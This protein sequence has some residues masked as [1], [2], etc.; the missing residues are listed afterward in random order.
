MLKQ[1]GRRDSEYGEYQELFSMNQAGMVN[2][3]LNAVS[4]VKPSKLCKE[5]RQHCR[6]PIHDQK[7]EPK[8]LLIRVLW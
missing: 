6:P 8:E 7:Q 1:R 4:V 3:H 5:C 2:A